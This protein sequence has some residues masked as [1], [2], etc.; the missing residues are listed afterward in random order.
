MATRVLV[1]DDEPMNAEMIALMLRFHGFDAHTVGDG[2]AAFSH[3]REFLPHVALLDTVMPRQDGRTITRMLRAEPWFG[4]RG[5]IVLFSSL[6]EADVGWREAGAD[7]FL[8]KP[9]SLREIPTLI[10]RLLGDRTLEA[11]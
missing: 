6:D 10:D 5:V 1:A 8:Q 2:A 9:F 11:L 4:T 3:A 7:A